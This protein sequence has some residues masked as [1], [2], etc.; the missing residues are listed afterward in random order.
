MQFVFK[1]SGDVTKQVADIEDM[2][3][4][5]VNGLVVFPF[6]SAALTPVVEKAYSRGVYVVVLDRG[7]TKPAY[8]VYLSNDD[9]S[10]ARRAM[11]WICKQLNYK[12]NIVFIEGVP[13]VISDLR[14]KTAKMV[15]EKYPGIK[16][17]DSQPGHVE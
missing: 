4:Q 13:S 16:V 9:E 14:T 3:V 15:A 5:G 8:D 6:E 2:L 7:I 17:L 12:G 11:E 1:T 10:Y